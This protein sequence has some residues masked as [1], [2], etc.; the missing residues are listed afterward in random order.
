MLEKA[1]SKSSLYGDSQEPW[2]P[3]EEGLV[4]TQK[5]EASAFSLQTWETS[6]FAHPRSLFSLLRRRV[7][8]KVTSGETLRPFPLIIWPLKAEIRKQIQDKSPCHLSNTSATCKPLQQRNFK[9][10]PAFLYWHLCVQKGTWWS[11]RLLIP[12]AICRT[13][14]WQKSSLPPPNFYIHF[15]SPENV[16]LAL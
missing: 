12:W 3:N 4:W 8:Q 5:A 6:P 9:A 13:V 15:P 7:G 2:S 1:K 10:I 14:Q 16:F 11:K